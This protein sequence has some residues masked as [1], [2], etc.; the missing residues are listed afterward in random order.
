MPR[1]TGFV[2]RTTV[3]W[4]QCHPSGALYAGHVPDICLRAIEAWWVH[5]WGRTWQR[6]NGEGLGTPFVSVDIDMRAPVRSGPLACETAPVR[7]GTRS[8]AFRVRG[9]Q[10]GEL[11]FDGRFACVFVDPGPFRAR[12]PPEELRALIG[13]WIDGRAPRLST[14]PPPDP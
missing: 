12:T 1:M 11:R 5:A 3:A 7:L 4:G 13:A 2:H 10:G 9:V 8:V 14:S 6:M